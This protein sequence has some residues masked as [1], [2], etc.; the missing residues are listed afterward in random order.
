MKVLGFA[1]P[2]G[3]GKTTLMTAVLPRLRARGL[4]VSTVKH[5]H[6]SVDLD[7]PGKDTY[8]HREAG[9]T[10]VVLVSSARF[11]VQHEYRDGERELELDELLARLT[12]VD[13][14]VVEGFRPYPHPKILVWRPALGKPRPAWDDLPGLIAIATDAPAT[15]SQLAGAPVPVLDLNDPDALVDFAIDRLGLA[16]TGRDV[17]VDG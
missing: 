15:E 9:A 16:P 11:V 2:S 7:R 1:G 12:P 8:R 3:S 14:V 13:V 10:E 17:G 6:H 5:T 4:S